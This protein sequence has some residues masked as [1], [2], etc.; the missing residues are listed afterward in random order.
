M[1]PRPPST[2]K[3]FGEAFYL[4]TRNPALRLWRNLRL[5]GYMA[6][7]VWTWAWTGGRVR[8]GVRRARRRGEVYHID[9]LA[10]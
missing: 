1:A 3:T 7:V 6:R 2:P 10:R 8:R 5:A 9:H 4:E